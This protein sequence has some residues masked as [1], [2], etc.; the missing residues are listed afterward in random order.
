MNDQ[1][2]YLLLKQAG[3]SLQAIF[4]YFKLKNKVLYDNS[5]G[6]SINTKTEI[7]NIHK[8]NTFYI[9]ENTTSHMP[10]FCLNDDGKFKG[11][12]QVND[13]AMKLANN[14]QWI[15]ALEGVITTDYLTVTAGH[16]MGHSVNGSHSAKHT[17]SNIKRVIG[18]DPIIPDSLSNIIGGGYC[19]TKFLREGCMDYVQSLKESFHR[20]KKSKVF[21]TNEEMGKDR[22]KL[23]NYFIQCG[24]I[25]RIAFS[26]I[27][28][29]SSY[30]DFYSGNDINKQCANTFCRD[31]QFRNLCEY[32]QNSHIG[33]QTTNWL[34]GRINSLRQIKEMGWCV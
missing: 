23:W 33:I 18:I 22:R 8:Y 24:Q 13:A 4:D 12:G 31:V 11:S 14:S 26:N 5:T 2:I 20:Y 19:L 7:P 21:E 27:F 3:D 16:S 15:L 1:E 17:I 28:R 32:K 9:Y 34:H 6:F 29:R 10:V 25:Q 30:Q